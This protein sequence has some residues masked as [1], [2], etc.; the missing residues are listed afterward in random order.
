MDEDFHKGHKEKTE[1]R[2]IC[3]ARVVIMPI[4]AFGMGGHSLTLIEFSG[5]TVK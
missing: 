4:H 3:H 1:Y 5:M 2:L